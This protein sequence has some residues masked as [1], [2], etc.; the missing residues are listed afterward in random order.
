MAFTPTEETT[1]KKLKR[2]GQTK[3]LRIEIANSGVSKLKQ[4]G[5]SE[6]LVFYC[7]DYF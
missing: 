2:A 4:G 1:G 5:K 7:I 3:T 6:D